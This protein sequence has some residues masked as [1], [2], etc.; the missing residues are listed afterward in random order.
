MPVSDVA[1]DAR[2]EEDRDR[3]LRTL[4][5]VSGTLQTEL[6]RLKS[7]RMNPDGEISSSTLKKAIKQREDSLKSIEK[8]IKILA[9][10]PEES[11][12]PVGMIVEVKLDK[13]SAIGVVVGNAEKNGPASRVVLLDDGA[14][15]SGSRP[16]EMV[17]QRDEMSV[18]ESA[19]LPD[20]VRAATYQ[21]EPTHINTVTNEELMVVKALGYYVHLKEADGNLFCSEINPS[22]PSE[23]P[24]LQLTDT[25]MSVMDP[26]GPGL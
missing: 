13:Q 16:S 10:N 19:L 8:Q 22:N 3:I 15:E 17:F 1:L 14:A 24:D 7:A 20:G 4:S 12:L 5:L 23:D 18:C 21:F 11:L 25:Y 26:D 6:Q 2:L 9:S